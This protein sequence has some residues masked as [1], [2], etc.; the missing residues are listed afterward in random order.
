MLW[1]LSSFQGPDSDTPAASP[2]SITEIK[3]RNAEM[4]RRQQELIEERKKQIEKEKESGISW[5]FKEDA[6]QSVGTFCISIVFD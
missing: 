2:Y 1:F 5:G 6:E 3:Q 4:K